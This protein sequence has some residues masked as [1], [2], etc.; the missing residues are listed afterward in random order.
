M[1]FIILIPPSF[2]KNLFCYLLFSLRLVIQKKS[3]I[4]YGPYL[5]P[6]SPF[7]S[8][9]D[10][11]SMAGQK[12]LRLVVF[13][14]RGKHGCA[15]RKPF[16]QAWMLL[17]PGICLSLSGKPFKPF[18]IQFYQRHDQDPYAMG[19]LIQKTITIS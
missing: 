13:L 8:L 9:E 14:T 4:A 11:G 15:S 1:F 2:V 3:P 17:T 18:L 7:P 16:K 10:G 6:E 12:I 19:D 5:L